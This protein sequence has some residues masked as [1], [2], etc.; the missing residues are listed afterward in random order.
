MALLFGLDTIN[1]HFNFVLFLLLLYPL[2]QDK[3]LTTPP[4]P[5]LTGARHQQFALQLVPRRV[6]P[7]PDGILISIFTC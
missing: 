3:I 5:V 2:M 4:F 6:V 1:P 7:S